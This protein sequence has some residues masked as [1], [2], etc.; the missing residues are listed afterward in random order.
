ML[1]VTHD[2]ALARYVSDRIVVMANGEI[3]ED[4]PTE[5]LLDDPAHAE[6]QQLLRAARHSVR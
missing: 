4:R 5:D 6:T 2:L 3:V 1:F